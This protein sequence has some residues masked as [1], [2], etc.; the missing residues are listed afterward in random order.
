MENISLKS[1]HLLFFSL[2]VLALCIFVLSSSTYAESL[3]SGAKSEA[4]A[5]THLSGP[6][7]NADCSDADE[8]TLSQTIQNGINFVS[9]VVGIIAVVMIIIGGIRFVVSNGDSAKVSTAKNTIMYALIG[10]ILV[11]LAQVIVKFVLLR[12]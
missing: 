10:L 6:A 2:A 11:A 8:T 1:K 3:F 9:I 7:T 4:C 12:I 5:G